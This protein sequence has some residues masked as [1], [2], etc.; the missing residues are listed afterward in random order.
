MT[1]RKKNQVALDFKKKLDARVL[2][3]RA[4]VTVGMTLKEFMLSPDFALPWLKSTI[5][6]GAPILTPVAEAI[7]DA[8]DGNPITTIDDATHRRIF[9]CALGSLPLKKALKYLLSGGGRSGKTS[10]FL[11]VV[12]A[13]CAW[14]VPLRLNPGQEAY[15]L[16][17]AP[18]KKLSIRAKQNVAG[19][20]QTSTVMRAHMISTAVETTKLRR[21][22][23][24]VV[25][26]EVTAKGP[27]GGRAGTCV[28]YGAD[29]AEFFPKDGGAY[30]LEEELKGA[31]QRVATG[32]VIAVVSTPLI[33]GEGYMQRTIAT[34][35]GRHVAVLCIEKV[36]TSELNPNWDPDGAKEAAYRAEYGDEA[37]DREY[38]AVPLARGTRRFFDAKKLREALERLAPKD[39]P[40]VGVGAGSDLGMRRDGCVLVV[41]RRHNNSIISVPSTGMHT[42]HPSDS[43]L[44]PSVVLGEF[45]VVARGLDAAG[46]A[47]DG[48]YAES[49]REE[50]NKHGLAFLDMPVG[51]HAKVALWMALAQVIGDDRLALGDLPEDKREDLVDQ[52]GRVIEKRSAQGVTIELPRRAIRSEADA[53]AGATDHCDGAVALR[54]AVWASGAGSGSVRQP[55]S[56]VSIPDEKPKP[57]A[58]PPK[59]R[60]VS[61]GTAPKI[62]GWGR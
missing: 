20:V 24:T 49:Y 21:P 31:G 37:A 9:G 46:I 52:L 58:A 22:D 40:I 2:R 54:N 34:E 62:K 26:I 36:W 13:W 50:I 6:E 18:T 55:G 3:D 59:V 29:E 56:P 47:A 32:G 5:P 10:R 17:S 41:V 35:R 16:I 1:R 39:A 4:G 28:F 61:F 44:I 45:G 14:T 51:A 19:L 48:V 53:S 27:L 30:D 33:D 43:N 57:V 25:S 15:A 42:A 11:V 12:A 8:I 23:G 7:V 38:R 60:G